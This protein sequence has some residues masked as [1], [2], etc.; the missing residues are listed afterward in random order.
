M[1]DFDAKGDLA[2]KGFDDRWTEGAFLGE[3]GMLVQLGLGMSLIM[4]KKEAFLAND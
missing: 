2:W 4:L 3:N 1:G